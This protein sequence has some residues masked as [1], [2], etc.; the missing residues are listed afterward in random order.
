MPSISKEI[1]MKIPIDIEVI[2]GLEIRKIPSKIEIIPKII[3]RAQG[4]PN[5]FKDTALEILIPP[6]KTTHAPKH[7]E[8]I[9][10]P[11]PGLN[12]SRMPKRVVTIP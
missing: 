11:K 7:R 3:T 5:L 6:V 10:L 2:I 9:M 1:P 12:R 4:S 8:N